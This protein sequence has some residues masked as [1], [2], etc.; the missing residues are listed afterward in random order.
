MVQRN[1]NTV[2]SFT[3]DGIG[4]HDLTLCIFNGREENIL[5]THFEEAIITGFGIFTTPGNH[6]YNFMWLLPQMARAVHLD[7]NSD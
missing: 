1:A 5:C 6:I 4:L 3:P 7:A 2:G